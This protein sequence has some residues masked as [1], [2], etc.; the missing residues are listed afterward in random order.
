M[1]NFSLERR[2]MAMNAKQDGVY[3]AVRVAVHPAGHGKLSVRTRAGYIPDGPH[4][5]GKR[6]D[7]K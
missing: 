6:E 4:S 7:A 2:R 3:R 5:T 1:L